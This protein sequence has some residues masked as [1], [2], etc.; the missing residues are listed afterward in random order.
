MAS[1]GELLVAGDAVRLLERVQVRRVLHVLLAELGVYK[2]VVLLVQVHKLA[3]RLLRPAQAP[4][5]PR[6]P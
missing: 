3:Q 1:L 2:D 6:A 5:V 4:G